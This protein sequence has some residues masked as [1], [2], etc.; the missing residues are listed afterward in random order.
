[1]SASDLS[2]DDA[3]PPS[4]RLQFSVRVSD[5]VPEAQLPN[6]DLMQ[7]WVWHTLASSIESDN[8]LQFEVSLSVVGRDEI[9]ALNRE[10][11]DQNKPTN[12]LSFPSDMPV[13]PG[14]TPAEG[15]HPLGDIV[16]CHD[17]VVAEAQ[18][19]HK[20]TEQHW[21]H[22]LIHSVLHLLGHD[23]IDSDEA[24]LMESLEVSLLAELSIPNPYQVSFET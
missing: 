21:A 13:L 9:Q 12:V 4:S 5:G 23:H 16:I 6:P 20:P 8:L 17:V 19:Q 2:R 18:A 11:R 7:R 1:M 22:M 3:E 14:D 24:T 15:L 10:Y